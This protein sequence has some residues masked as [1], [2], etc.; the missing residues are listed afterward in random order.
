MKKLKSIST[1]TLISGLALVLSGCVQRDKHGNPY[2]PIYDYLAI[3]AQHF[4][5]YLSHLLGGSYGLAIILVTFVVRLILLPLMLNQSRKAT[6]Q[7][8]KMAFIQPQLKVLQARNQAAKTPEERAAISQEMMA[9]YK[10]NNVS[11]TG[12]IGCLPIIIQFPVFAALYAAIQYSPEL[13][14]GLFL[15]INLAKPSILL[16]AISFLVYLLQGWL[17]TLGVAP[18]QR[19][20]MRSMMIVSPLMILFFT[21]SSPGGLGLYFAVG[22]VF[23]CIQTLA[24]NLY[25]PKIKARIQEEMKKNP[26]KIVEPTGPVDLKNVTEAATEVTSEPETKPVSKPQNNKPRRNAGKQ[27]HHRD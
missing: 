15:G 18:E 1:I 22:G 27:N 23:A 21:F 19:K 9:L 12:G 26:P 10:D 7:Q 11:M 5:N 6:I 4:M 3:P 20:M 25:R 24:I 17:G 13:H 16:A 14:Q 2:G 8:E